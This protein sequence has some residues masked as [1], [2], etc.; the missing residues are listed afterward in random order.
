MHLIRNEKGGA[1][2]IVF[3][4][5]VLFTVLGYGLASTTMQSVKQRT[6]AEDE[7]QGKLLAEAG[8][9]YFKEYL[10]TSLS[11]KFNEYSR[12]L[13][14]PNPVT[15]TTEDVLR[16]VESIASTDQNGESDV[17][18]RVTIP[19][20]N[21]SF[22]IHYEVA[23]RIPRAEGSLSQPYVLKLNVSVLG[24]P[25]R[26]ENLRQVRLN[27]TV[28]INT[29][30]APFHY[31]VSTP[32]ELR[33][34][35]GSN[36]I[37]N[38]AAKSLVTSTNYR[39]S[40]PNGS[41]PVWDTDGHSANHPYIEGELLIPDRG[42]ITFIDSPPDN[43]PT[44]I[45][46]VR[47]KEVTD[48][49]EHFTPR[50]FSGGTASET[51]SYL[52]SANPDTPYIPGFE[53]PTVST[54]N[55]PDLSLFSDMDVGNFVRSR[56]KAAG[57]ATT[58]FQVD[59]DHSI[60]FEE[61]AYNEGFQTVSAPKETT[62]LVIRSP[63][64]GAPATVNL[65]ARLTGN[66]LP[67]VR[68][69]YIGGAFDPSDEDEKGV[70]SVEMG[71]YGSFLDPANRN[72][73]PFT[74]NGTIYIKGSLD[75]VGDIN[76]NGTIYVDGNVVIREI[77]NIGSNNLVIIASGTISLTDRYAGET[78]FNN[79]GTISAFLYSGKAMQ[80]YSINSHNRIRGGIATGRN[81][82]IELNTK[83]ETT[84]DMPTRMAL[85]FHRRIFEAATPGLPPGDRFHID[86][87]DRDYPQVGNVI[88]E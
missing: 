44:E 2:V 62:T 80:I 9:V 57:Q 47:R 58:G 56:I 36:I 20:L 15:A 52:L 63:Y 39:Y 86:I 13:D 84:G 54:Q 41:N 14:D 34:F 79:P 7:V 28:Y 60:Q 23:N 16:L 65:T 87:Y 48:V 82:Y 85:S 37:G 67:E 45:L 43:E 49:D 72:G 59:E 30:P 75:I 21:G 11:A 61:P 12:S 78:N 26:A 3:F 50:T 25:N 88:I 53:A 19:G 70:A 6:F 76:I 33:L 46:D 32:G 83:R 51:N 35:G 4:I 10:E 38:V 68:T 71:R 77:E 29:I 24:I 18:Q 27:A 5:L 31:A 81:G 22:A 55:F 42:S 64:A 66:S 17:F 69:L 74:F 8:L 73:D 40:T 1:L